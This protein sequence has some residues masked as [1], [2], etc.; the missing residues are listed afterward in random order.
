MLEISQNF[1]SQKLN[2]K[3]LAPHNQFNIHMVTRILRVIYAIALTESC[4]NAHIDGLND[5]TRESIKGYSQVNTPYTCEEL[6]S[7]IIAVRSP[8]DR[9]PP[10]SEDL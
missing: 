9:T 4:T 5:K 8:M 1:T 2:S 7:V 3:H 6:L 10:W